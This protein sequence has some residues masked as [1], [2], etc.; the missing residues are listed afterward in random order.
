[1]SE[2]ETLIFNNVYVSTSPY[3]IDEGFNSSKNDFQKNRN[4]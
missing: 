3:N 4:K 1:M 2:I